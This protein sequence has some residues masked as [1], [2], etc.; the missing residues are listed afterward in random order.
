MEKI[1]HLHE[2]LKDHNIQNMIISD[3]YS[4]RYL[5]GYY[6]EPGER[7]LALVVTPE[8]H[9]LILNQLFPEFNSTDNSE[10]IYYHDGEP[11]METIANL[12]VEGTTSIDKFWPSQFLLELMSI[13]P[14]LQAVN[15]TYILDNLRGIKSIEEINIMREASKRNDQVMERLVASLKEGLSEE[16]YSNQLKSFY[17][18]SDHQGF[19]FEP[20]VAYGA[21]G[22]DPHHTT[23][24]SLPQ[25][26]DPVVLDIGGIY[27]GYA[28]DMTRTVFFGQPSQHA[29]KVYDIVHRANL[30]AI[31][32]V[33]AG[34]PLSDIDLAA[35]R[36]IEEAGYGQYFTHR[37]GHFIGQEAHEAGDV[38]QF[39]HAKAQVGQVFS[40]EPGIYLPGQFG[41]RIEDLVVVTEDGCEVL[42][43]F[44]KEP[45]ILDVQ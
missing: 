41:V 22:A 3:P 2:Q 19:S 4:I 34:V 18:V 9:Y 24:E 12:L 33:K 28:S 20:I 26:G 42:N 11:I 44:T 45:I 39:N 8:H 38:S 17:Q 15:A 43:S 14:E 16:E 25:L 40:I 21:N 13:Q 23:D 35:R 6:T 36:L 31:A 30:A 1:Q 10:V 27:Q 5:V 32:T 29:L 37:L 7:L